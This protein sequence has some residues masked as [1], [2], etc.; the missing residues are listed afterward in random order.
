MSIELQRTVES[1]QVGARHRAD[2]G[3]I[4]AL[5]DSIREHGLLQPITVTPEGVLVCGRRR[6]EAIRLLH[7]RTVSVWVRSGV[8][9]R[10]GHLLAEQDENAHRKPLNQLEAAALYRELKQLMTE[11][12]QRRDVVTRFSAENQPGADG[13]AK[14]APPSGGVG[15]RSRAQAA[16]M[17]TGRA[18]YTTLEKISAIQAMAENPENPE[19]LREQA[20]T[21][22][23]GI[24]AGGPV[25]P[26]YQRLR[27]QVEQADASR[28]ASL[29]AMAQEAVARVTAAGRTKPRTHTSARPAVVPGRWPVT[30]FVQTWTS[31]AEWWTHY[32][33]DE[34]ARDLTEEQAGIFL[35]VADGTSAFAARLRISLDTT[36]HDVETTTE[37]PRTDEDTG[38]GADAESGESVSRQHLRAL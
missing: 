15:G 28:Q 1:I 37:E 19:A 33:V 13:G 17:V 31:L 11:D 12:A 38:P 35:D 30:A 29:R 25:D 23:A 24:E 8:S 18:S 4:Q 36:G 3:D 2:L 10:L 32:D 27:G 22:L 6:L 5:A 34:L 7:W 9:T 20:T 14:L 21:E 16:R 26:A